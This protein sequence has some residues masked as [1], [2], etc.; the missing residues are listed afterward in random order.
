MS[1][2]I[3]IVITGGPGG[4]KTTAIDIFRREFIDKV[5]VV[6]ESAT[7]IFSSGIRRSIKMDELKATQLTIY[8]LQQNM[9]KLIIAQNP[10]HSLICDRGTLDGLAYWPN[11]E[12][13]F[14][15]EI[16]TNFEDELNSYDAVIFF[17]TAARTDSNITS[18]NLFRTESN[19]QA[20]ELDTK[21]QKIW[22]KHPQFYLIKSNDSF[23]D[24]IS[25]GVKTI[26][27]VLE[28]FN[29]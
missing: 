21:L 13:T 29:H 18:N 22:E 24:K 6:P 3:K 11:S 10:G 26:K 27:A 19:K 7:T 9:E 8:N 28:T 16:Q 1:K 15:E 14:F 4:G 25:C 5:S 20:I 2:I 23:I 12:A 17:Q